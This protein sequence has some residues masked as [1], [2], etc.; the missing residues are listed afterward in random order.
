MRKTKAITVV[1][2]LF[3]IVTSKLIAQ[4]SEADKEKAVKLMLDMHCYFKQQLS[5]PK[6]KEWKPDVISSKIGPQIYT[7]SEFETLMGMFKKSLLFEPSHFDKNKLR[8][9]FDAYHIPNE[10]FSKLTFSWNKLRTEN[11]K[12]IPF[13]SD[14]V[15]NIDVFSHTDVSKPANIKEKIIKLEGELKM[16]YYTNSKSITFNASEIGK[17]KSIDGVNITLKALENGYC[18]YESDMKISD[19]LITECFSKNKEMLGNSYMVMSKLLDDMLINYKYADK[20][21]CTVSDDVKKQYSKMFNDANKDKIWEKGLIVQLIASGT[22]DFIT[23][24]LPTDLK[25]KTYPI[26]AFHK[27]NTSVINDGDFNFR[28]ERYANSKIKRK[29]DVIDENQLKQQVSI[30]M[31]SANSGFFTEGGINKKTLEIRLPKNENTLFSEGELMNLSTLVNGKWQKINNYKW[32]FKD[33]NNDKLA[34]YPNTVTPYL[35]DFEEI[36]GELSVKYPASF[37]VTSK[38]KPVLLNK[39]AIEKIETAKKAKEDLEQEKDEKSDDDS[40]KSEEKTIY[41]YFLK[42]KNTVTILQNRNGDSDADKYPIVRAFDAFGVELKQEGVIKE[43]VTMENIHSRDVYKNY[44][45]WGEIAT[46]KLYEIDKWT[47]INI[48]FQLKK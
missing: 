5:N 28:R 47:T 32:Q 36:R 18:R 26:A 37:I 4:N 1:F 20:T 40:S 22:I 25:T 46:L 12:E 27:F 33:Y 24:Y 35:N 43:G 38:S 19:K 9:D 44:P 42:N 45:F 2:L 13:Q 17:T 21:G 11:K 48:P 3:S 6:N 30:Y 23:I 39:Q 15:V 31:R 8:V 41:P 10:R 29:F 16:D 14:E 34:I 7:E